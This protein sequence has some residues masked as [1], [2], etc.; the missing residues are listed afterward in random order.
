MGAFVS[1]LDAGKIYQTWPLMD[2]SY[3]PNDTYFNK[4]TDVIDFNN[5]GLVQFYHRNIAYFILVY[6][7]LIGFYIFKKKIFYLYKPFH[8]VFYLLL[9]QIIIGIITLL[10]G[11]NIYL[12][13]AHQIIGLLL[14]L[15]TI[16]LYYNSIN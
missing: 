4:F 8:I 1:G 14:M 6:V 13:S 2:Y 12:A 10:S 9:L 15:S 5:Q 3:F 11:I 16:N 7:F